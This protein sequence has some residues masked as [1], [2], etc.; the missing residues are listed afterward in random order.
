MI[1]LNG[2][3]NKISLLL[4]S[5]VNLLRLE[6]DFLHEKS[7]V[8]ISND[9]SA[10]EERN[11]LSNFSGSIPLKFLDET[12]HWKVALH[13]FGLHVMQKQNLCPKSSSH[14]AVI[15]IALKDLYSQSSKHKQQDISKLPLYMFRE[16]NMIFIDGRKSYSA[17]SLVESFE[18]QV[19]NVIKTNPNKWCGMPVKFNENGNFIMIGQFDMNGNDYEETISSYDEDEK[20]ERRSF[21]FLNEYFKKGL[22][23]QHGSHTFKKTNI[24]GEIYYYF[25]NSPVFREKDFYPF[26]SKKNEFPIT[27]PK[28]MQIISPDIEHAINN[29]SYSQCLKQFTVDATEVG[30]YIHREFEN[31]E[32][33]EV[34]DK[35]ID[36]F[37]I[38]ITDGNSEKIRLTQ[39]LPTWVKL[40]F[41]SNMKKIEHVRITSEPN[42]LH[43]DNVMSS[44]TVELPQQLDFTWQKNPRVALSRISFMNK[45]ELMPGLRLD[46]LIYNIETDEISHFRCPKGKS[47]PRTC[48]EI[49]KWFEKEAKKNGPTQI[50]RDNDMENYTLVFGSKSILIIGRDLAQ[51]LGLWSTNNEK[52]I[53]VGSFNRYERDKDFEKHI[54]KAVKGYDATLNDY[55]SFSANGDYL[56]YC[57]EVF[58]SNLIGSNKSFIFPLKSPP[59]DIELYPNNLYIFSNIVKPTILASEFRRLIRI[60]PLPHDKKD[61]NISIDFSTPEFHNLSELHPKTLQFEIVTIDGRPVKPFFS[62]HVYMSLQFLYD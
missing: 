23:L 54:E 37:E 20:G 32:F 46:F 5:N 44:F 55:K 22:D 13:S 11:T 43:K 59:L 53:Y 50:T 18:S 12:K 2:F 47:G 41:V 29:N 15:H 40:V 38:K 14:P 49:I 6:M 28:I 58:E 52:P 42:I 45:W 26:K 3:Q 27:A 34:L 21:V 48:E 25:Y 51:C 36:S 33:F 35:S 57:E 56:I 31:Y 60:I 62:S 61:Q 1:S 16:E 7:V 9:A 8:L 17:K 30:K 39:G 19:T 24:D 4:K 10:N